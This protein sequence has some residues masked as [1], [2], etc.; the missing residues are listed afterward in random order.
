VQVH[1]DFPSLRLALERIVAVTSWVDNH[2]RELENIR[3]V[4]LVQECFIGNK[5]PWLA[6]P[7]RRFVKESCVTEKESSKQV[8]LHLFND[9]L[10]ISR[11][12]RRDKTKLKP[13]YIYELQRLDVLPDLAAEESPVLAL[14]FSTTFHE[15]FVE[16][17][18]D[19][20]D[21]CSTI[22]A[23]QRSL[24]APNAVRQIPGLTAQTSLSTPRSARA[25]QKS[26]SVKKLS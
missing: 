5:L 16:S 24:T 11:P 26:I 4:L 2:E 18:E 13:L 15:F 20:K 19:K 8:Y 25:L 6:I 23:L 7:A 17:P 9:M 1:V 22:C 14:R 10:I 12:S 21:W 3:K